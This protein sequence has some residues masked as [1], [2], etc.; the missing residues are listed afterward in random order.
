MIRKL[1]LKFYGTIFKAKD[2]SEVPQSQWVAFLAQDDA[3]VMTLPTYLE[4]CIKM[5]CDDAQIAAVERLM[6]NVNE[7]RR[8]DPARNKKPD[9]VGEAMIDPATG[10]IPI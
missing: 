6:A 3:F 9:A 4:N 5:G 8:A 10:E 7:V 2:G 1:D